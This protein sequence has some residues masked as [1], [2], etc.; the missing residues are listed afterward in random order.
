[1]D[2]LGWLRIV[3]FLGILGGASGDA[4]QELRPNRCDLLY[5]NRVREAEREIPG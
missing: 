3:A 1:M 5:T 2:G 4:P